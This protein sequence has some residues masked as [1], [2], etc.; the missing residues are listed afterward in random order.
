MKIYPFQQ[1]F[2]FLQ[3]FD[4]GKMF[5]VTFFLFLIF[6]FALYKQKLH[7][8]YTAWAT[9]PSPRGLPIVNNLLEFIGER[10][11][12]PLQKVEKWRRELGE[13]YLVTI[14]A[15]DCGT[16]VVANPEVAEAILL[17]QPDRSRS[18]FYYYLFEWLGKES[19]FLTSNMKW[20]QTMKVVN[21][22]L[23]HFCEDKVNEHLQIF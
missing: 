8:R 7:R 16:V 15:F 14:G 21:H 20:K 22:S 17:H 18:S 9:F 19:V 13:V 10:G 6:V 3:H 11:K 1:R 12:Y 2:Q 23:K 4:E 5:V